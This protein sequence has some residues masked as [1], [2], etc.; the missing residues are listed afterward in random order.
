MRT[1]KQIVTARDTED[2]LTEKET[3]SFT[4]DNQEADIC[5]D[6]SITYQSIF[7]FGGAFTEATAYTLSQMSEDKRAEVLHKYFDQ[8]EGIGYNIGRVHIHSCDFALENYTYV[9]EGDVDL[10]TFDISRDHKWVLPLLKDAMKVK[11]DTIPLLASPWSPPAWMK[12]NQDMNNGGQL[13]PEYQ[14]TWAKYYAT[15]IQEYQREGLEIW[16]VSVQNEPAA[17]QVWDSCIYS[18]EEERDFVKNHLGPTLHENGLEDINILIWDHNRDQIVERASTVLSDPEA[19]K[20]VWGTGFHWYV[21]EDFEQVGEVHNRFP[22]K[23]LLFTEGCQE[24]GVKLGEWFTGE[25]Y[26]RN[27]IGDLNNWTE[28]YLDWNMVLNEDGGP[29]HVQNLCDAPIIA[30]TKTNELHYNS[31][32]YYIGHFSKFIRPGALRIGVTNHHD[33]LETTSFRNK[34]GSIAVV[35]M[36]ESDEH[37]AFSLGDCDHLIHFELPA[38]S[39]A[40][41]IVN[42]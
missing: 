17:V 18:A 35:V 32:Y 39:I 38:H 40:T 42:G 7:G 36:N 14:Q 12:T 24:G 37:Q 3:V 10:A 34:D 31:S 29:N 20:Y 4:S 1:V 26:G 22:D 16:G 9:Q 6:P 30:D 11:G 25:R 23:H 33:V 15:F 27:M 13:L 28:G 5:I 21:S 8:N 41:Y 19:A 2:R